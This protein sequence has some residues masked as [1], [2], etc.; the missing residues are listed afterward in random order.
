MWILITHF[1]VWPLLVEHLPLAV[2][3]VLTIATGILAAI[4][5]ERAYQ[6]VRRWRGSPVQPVMAATISS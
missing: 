3:Y 2:A 4:A 6:L 5:F 1:T